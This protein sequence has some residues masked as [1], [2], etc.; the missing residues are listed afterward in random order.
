MK[1]LCLTIISFLVS[2]SSLSSAKKTVVQIIP[3]NHHLTTV[4]T[5]LEGVV[6]I[7]DSET[8]EVRVETSVFF[9]S[10]KEEVIS[11]GE[12]QGYYDLTTLFSFDEITLTIAPKR[13][14]TSVFS[15]GEKQELRRQYR[16]FLPS[17]VR[18]MD[19]D[20]P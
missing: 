4:K 17:H 6:E 11:Y 1:I 18:Y 16:I 9:E 14:N 7:V 8:Y 10:G 20:C 12:K 2:F 19:N 13:I 5:T 15:Q 3:I